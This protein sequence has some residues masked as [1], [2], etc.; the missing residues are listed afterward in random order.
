ML[1]ERPIPSDSTA[2]SVVVKIPRIG[3]GSRMAASATLLV[4]ARW[5]FK[6]SDKG[7]LMVHTWL[8]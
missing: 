1:Q 4:E 7:E 5:Q 3:T 8:N 2:G 6:A